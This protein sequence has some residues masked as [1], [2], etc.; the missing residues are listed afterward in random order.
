[1][2]MGGTWA[3]VVTN[4][5]TCDRGE[6]VAAYNW[7]RGAWVGRKISTKAS[8][9]IATGVADASNSRI[10]CSDKA[11]VYKAMLQ[12]IFTDSQGNWVVDARSDEP[13]SQVCHSYA[14]TAAHYTHP[15]EHTSIS[16]PCLIFK[17]VLGHPL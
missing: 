8:W 2:G 1:M 14:H 12:T 10:R 16:H 7:T 15:P 17:E 11:K 13:W 4:R 5:A 3:W 6:V 9:G